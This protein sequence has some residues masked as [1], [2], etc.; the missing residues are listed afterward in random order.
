VKVGRVTGT[1]VSTISEPFFDGKRLL[2]CDL[3]DA[4][5]EPRGYTIA[6]DVVDAGVGDTVL[7][8]DEGNSARQIFGLETGAIRAVVVGI[9]DELVV[10]GEVLPVV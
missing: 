5:G 7:I 2:L 8:I 6:V 10:D 1:V 4:A 3:L 9:V